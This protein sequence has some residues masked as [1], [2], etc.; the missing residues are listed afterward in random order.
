MYKRQR[1]AVHVKSKSKQC[2]ETELI[3]ADDNQFEQNII[4]TA[5]QK[6]LIGWELSVVVDT[7]TLSNMVIKYA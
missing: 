7:L 3:F 5:E 1:H 2:N 4:E 6:P